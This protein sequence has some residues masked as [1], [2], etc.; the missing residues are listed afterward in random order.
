MLDSNALL[1]TMAETLDGLDVAM[2]VFDADDRALLW[3]RAFLQRFP[4]HAGHIHAG[5]PYSANLRRFYAGRLGP[6]E[7]GSIDRYI[8]EGI[9]RH[10]QQQRPYAFEHRGVALRV[11]SLPLPGIGRVRLWVRDDAASEAA[12]EAPRP[13]P[14]A[15]ALFEQ[16]GDGVMLTDAGGSVAW[17]NAPFVLLYALADQAAAVGARFE[18]VYRSA[19]QGAAGEERAKFDEGLSTLVENLRYS[20]APF[21][22]PLPGDRWVR[23]VEQRRPDGTGCSAHVDISVLKRQQQEL[24]LAERRARDSEARLAEKSRLLEATLEHMEQGVMMVGPEGVVE[25]CNRRAMEL[26]GLPAALVAT[27]PSFDEVLAH[28][29]WVDDSA[30]RPEDATGCAAGAGAGAD[31]RSQDRKR[32][33]GRVVEV[34]CAPIDGGGV[35]RTYTDVT[36]RRRSEAR[37]RHVARHDGLTSLVKREAFLEHVAEA[38]QQPGRFAVHYLDLDDFKPVNDRL[39]HAIGDQLLTRVAERMRRIV[40]EG[41]VVGRMGGDEFAIL[42]P[43]VEHPEQTLGLAGRLVQGI[44]QPIEIE[45]HVVRV[46]VSIGIALHPEHGRSAD[47]LMRCADAALYEAKAGGRNEVRVYCE[48]AARPA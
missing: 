3:N 33:D 8:A 14:D 20:G 47:R 12:A 5:E 34:R 9:A 35:L 44:R 46:G 48:P 29:R 16:V 15:F 30:G 4:E 45:G 38:L 28:Q 2:C 10:R 43:R 1:Q 39:G 32:A 41:D 26:L 21:E 25:V 11:A 22:L 24:I 6:K 19:W 18:D 17:V 31:S 13:A 7:I 27:K 37:I 42:Q 23:I 36:E 40:R